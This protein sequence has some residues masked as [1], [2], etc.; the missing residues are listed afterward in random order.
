MASLRAWDDFFPNT[1]IVEIDE[2]T[3]VKTDKKFERAEELHYLR[4][5]ATKVRNILGWKPEYTFET[6]LD[7]M[8]NY[9]IEYYNQ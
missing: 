4:G 8:I 7:E 3:Y 6:A 5:D 1:N 9:W 2:S